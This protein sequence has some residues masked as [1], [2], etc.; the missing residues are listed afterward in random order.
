MSSYQYHIESENM[1]AMKKKII[2]YKKQNTV[3]KPK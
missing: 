1:I 2:I 3:Q